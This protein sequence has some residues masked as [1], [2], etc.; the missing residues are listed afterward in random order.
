MYVRAQLL[1]IDPSQSRQIMRFLEGQLIPKLRKV[2]GFR[3]YTAAGDLTTGKALT[4]TQCE[5]LEQAQ[6]HLSALGFGQEIA[7]LGIEIDAI[8]VYE[9]LAQA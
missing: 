7:D 9:V 6:S 1:S 5:T 2:P 3:R 8:Y 4:V